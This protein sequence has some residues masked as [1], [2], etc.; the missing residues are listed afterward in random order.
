M[1]TQILKH[2]LHSTCTVPCGMRSISSLFWTHIIN[3]YCHT[4]Y[5]CRYIVDWMIHAWRSRQDTFVIYRRFIFVYCHTK[6]FG[7]LQRET[8]WETIKWRRTEYNSCYNQFYPIHYKHAKN[9][10]DKVR[11]DTP[12]IVCTCWIAYK[13]YF[14]ADCTFYD[15]VSQSNQL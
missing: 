15:I 9:V 8:H 5:R 4:Q 10:T 13:L 1:H 12:T 3:H 2:L 6:S 11:V 7:R 14:Y